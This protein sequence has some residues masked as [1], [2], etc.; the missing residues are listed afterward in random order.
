MARPDMAHKEHSH[1]VRP[2]RQGLYLV[3]MAIKTHS[4]FYAFFFFR[5]SHRGNPYVRLRL[6]LSAREP[7]GDQ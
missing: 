6:S 5:L 3:R 2:L 7:T 4:R 1:G